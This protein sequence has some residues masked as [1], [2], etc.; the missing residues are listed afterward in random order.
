MT[1]TPECPNNVPHEG[2]HTVTSALR[3][4]RKEPQ[5]GAS[6]VS[7]F[8]AHCF[9]SGQRTNAESD[10]LFPIASPKLGIQG[11]TAGNPL[12]LSGPFP[13]PLHHS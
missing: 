2:S 9:W 5:G 6:P 12:L 10:D 1:G 3:R 11:N 8:P 13:K 4:E 7:L